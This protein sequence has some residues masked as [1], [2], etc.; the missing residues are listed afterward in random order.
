MFPDVSMIFFT[1]YQ[2][3]LFATSSK[4]WEK[5][6]PKHGEFLL[7]L[8]ALDFPRLGG[9]CGLGSLNGDLCQEHCAFALLGALNPGLDPI[10]RG[11]AESA[12]PFVETAYCI[13][14]NKNNGLRK[15]SRA[16]TDCLV[17]YN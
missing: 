17:P 16:S 2:L 14:K 15:D 12:L 13:L 3:I 8:L 5:H 1:S 9:L 6:K 10:R 11:A 7:H 4:K